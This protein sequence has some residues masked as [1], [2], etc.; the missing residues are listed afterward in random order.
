M[1]KSSDYC[2]IRMY[3]INCMDM[4]RGVPRILDNRGYFFN[5]FRLLKGYIV[6]FGCIFIRGVDLLYKI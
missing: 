4:A 3:I 2:E 1:I 6:T 5:L